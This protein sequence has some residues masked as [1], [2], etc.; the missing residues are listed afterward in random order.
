[1]VCNVGGVDRMGRFII[2]VVLL[3]IGF[4]APLTT[5]WQI[6]IFVV[7]AIALIT[8]LVRY[9]PA[10]AILG[11]NTCRREERASRGT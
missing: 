3:I 2:G 11:I 8:A 6:A 4:L 10:N 5:G 7:A 1:M 9:C